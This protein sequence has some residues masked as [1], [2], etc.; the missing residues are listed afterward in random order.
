MKK[1][2]HPDIKFTVRL[3]NGYEGQAHATTDGWLN[4]SSVDGSQRAAIQTTPV[5]LLAQILL[6]EI[7]RRA[8]KG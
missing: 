7:A 1:K 2:K 4:V 5:E 3:L 6:G 8:G